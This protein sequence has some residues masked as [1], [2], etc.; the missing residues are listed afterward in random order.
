MLSRNQKELLID[1]LDSIRDYE[2]ESH[3]LIGFD[4]RENIEF[5]EIY[6]NSLKKRKQ[7]NKIKEKPRCPECGSY[8]LDITHSDKQH[9][10]FNCG[11]SWYVK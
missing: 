10:C 7:S 1:F 6:E 9:D 8:N 4:E 3:N 2:R 5:V 11:K